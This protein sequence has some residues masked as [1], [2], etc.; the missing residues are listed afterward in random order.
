MKTTSW[1]EGREAPRRHAGQRSVAVEG[2]EPLWVGRTPTLL[3]GRSYRA[4]KRAADVAAAILAI[5]FA[6]PIVAACAVALWVESPSA[7]IFFR[8]ERTGR[9]GRRFTMYKLRTM[10]PNA[11][12]MKLELAP[13]NEMRWPDFKIRHDP[14]VTRVGRFLRAT[15]LDE[16]PQLVNILRGE[17]GLIGPRPTSFTPSTYRLWQTERLDVRPGLTGLWQ[18]CGRGDLEFDDRVR[19][20]IAY[21]DHCSLGLDLAIVARTIGVVLRG[22][23]S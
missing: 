4:L 10:R 9:Y 14:R 1:R 12:R 17:M 16:L 8:Q 19:L 3:G 15:S 23:G 22:K 18:V 6:L 21:I 20:D 5:P 13:M 11:E 2:V 7:P